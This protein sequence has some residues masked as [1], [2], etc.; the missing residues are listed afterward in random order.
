MT[1]NVF[2]RSKFYPHGCPLSYSLL[3]PLANAEV[4]GHSDGQWFYVRLWFYA[5]TQQPESHQG[6]LC[7]VLGSIVITEELSSNIFQTWTKHSSNM[8]KLLS[9]HAVLYTHEAYGC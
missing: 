7:N 6:L 2:V 9:G 8:F 5:V 3:T 4:L 1:M